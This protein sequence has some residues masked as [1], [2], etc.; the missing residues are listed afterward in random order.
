MQL[1]SEKG[2]FAGVAAMASD[3]VTRVSTDKVI[4]AKKR[5]FTGCF[6]L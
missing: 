1:G 5:N 6:R 4:D 3:Q 2:P